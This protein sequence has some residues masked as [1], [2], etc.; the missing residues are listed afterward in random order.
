MRILPVPQEEEEA[1]TAELMVVVGL[2]LR[3]VSSQRW[4]RSMPSERVLR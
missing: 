2:L 4:T 1:T 3:G